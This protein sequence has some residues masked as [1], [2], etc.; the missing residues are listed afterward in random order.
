M[1]IPSLDLDDVKRLYQEHVPGDV[2]W[3]ARTIHT[4]LLMATSIL[5]EGKDCGV[6][7]E[8]TLITIDRQYDY[9]FDIRDQQ[10]NLLAPFTK[11]KPFLSVT[12]PYT[13]L[14]GVF[15][16]MGPVHS[17]KVGLYKNSTRKLVAQSTH[18]QKFD[19]YRVMYRDGRVQRVPTNGPVG[20]G[21]HRFEEE[22]LL[23][24]NPEKKRERDVLA[25]LEKLERDMKEL[26]APDSVL[27]R[28]GA[29]CYEATG[30]KVEDAEKEE[31]YGGL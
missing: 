22:L 9:F 10:G 3:E 21:M 14:T 28:A 12:T 31:A 26:W 18:E 23:L 11:E 29:I 8:T 16:E 6:H 17:A 4:Q 1:N 7:A 15:P 13:E 19:N 5:P 30:A 20:D 27:V 2:N 24:L 25:R